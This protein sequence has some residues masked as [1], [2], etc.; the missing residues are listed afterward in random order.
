MSLYNRI[1]VNCIQK[2]TLR[3]SLKSNSNVFPL[4]LTQLGVDYS[5]A[6]QSMAKSLI[7]ARCDMA[8]KTEEVPL[9]SQ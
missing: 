5:L 2:K 3:I 4:S 6:E 8:C 7:K 1:K 9:V